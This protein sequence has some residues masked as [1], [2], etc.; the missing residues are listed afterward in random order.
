MAGFFFSWINILASR[1]LAGVR[2][3]RA[4]KSRQSP[5]N[6]LQVSYTQ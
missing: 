5:A 2:L 4:M 1:P 3:K 6:S